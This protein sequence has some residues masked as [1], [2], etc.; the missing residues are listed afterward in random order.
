M[1]KRRAEDELLLQFEQLQQAGTSRSA[2]A[3]RI[4]VP[5]GTLDGILA[6]ARKR[7]CAGEA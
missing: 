4:D 1:A 5:V 3:V 6:R 2:F 7:R